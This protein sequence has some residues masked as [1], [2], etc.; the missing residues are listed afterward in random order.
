MSSCSCADSACPAPVAPDPTIE[1]PP[2]RATADSD[3]TGSAPRATADSDLTGSAPRAVADSASSRSISTKGS[4]RCW[5]CSHCFF[6]ATILASTSFMSFIG[7]WNY[8]RRQ[9]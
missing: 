1:F 2:P 6:A 8:R 3:L 7:R 4:A 9:I 5:R